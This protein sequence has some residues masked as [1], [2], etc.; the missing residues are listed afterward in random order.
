MK[1]ISSF[2]RTS[3]RVIASRLNHLRLSLRDLRERLR[4]S[5]VQIIGENLGRMVR[6]TLQESLHGSNSRSSRLPRQYSD[7]WDGSD[8]YYWGDPNHWENEYEPDPERGYPEPTRSEEA[9][10][11]NPLSTALASGF[12]VVAWGLRRWSGTGSL[13]RIV[14]CGLVVAC[15]AYFFGSFA[16]VGLSLMETADHL[17]MLG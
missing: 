2:I 13:L 14:G 6:E 5:V 16:S 1:T 15:A 10:P 9:T 7:D 4:A 3:R 12:R 17:S 8:E 11:S